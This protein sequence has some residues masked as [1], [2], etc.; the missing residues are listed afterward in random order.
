MGFRLP[1]IDTRARWT[2]PLACVDDPAAEKHGDEWAGVVARYV[3]SGDPCDLSADGLMVTIRPLSAAEED[4]CEGEAGPPV[5]LAGFVYSAMQRRGVD[6]NNSEAVAR[7]TAAI[8]EPERAALHAHDLRMGRLR[9]ARAKRALIAA[10]FAGEGESA[11][12]AL[13]RIASPMRGHVLLEIAAHLDRLTT[14]GAE[15]KAPAGER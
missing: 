5:P 3:E 4:A 15:G 11:A 12:D 1:M 14:L 7:A 13:D 9:A 10:D 6:L 2:G 8:P